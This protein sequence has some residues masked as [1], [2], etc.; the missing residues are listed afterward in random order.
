M[1][2]YSVLQQNLKNTATRYL[3]HCS[4]AVALLKHLIVNLDLLLTSSYVEG[5]LYCA[6]GRGQTLPK[7]HQRV[8]IR[9]PKSVVMSRDSN[10]L[11]WW[12]GD[13]AP[14]R[15]CQRTNPTHSP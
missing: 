11:D 3:L 5:G 1:R 6:L 14:P 13:P 9:S 10:N 12:L 15:R 7:S 8:L 2:L 4:S